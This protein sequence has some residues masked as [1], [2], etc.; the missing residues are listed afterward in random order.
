MMVMMMMMMMMMIM[1]VGEDIDTFASPRGD[2]YLSTKN[3]SIYL[4]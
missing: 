3:L 2:I 4:S 1:A